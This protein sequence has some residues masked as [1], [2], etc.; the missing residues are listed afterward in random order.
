MTS[1]TTPKEKDTFLLMPMVYDPSGGNKG[2]ARRASSIR[3]L[4]LSIPSKPDQLNNF[5]FPEKPA[6]LFYHRKSTSKRD[7]THAS[8]R[9]SARASFT[10]IDNPSSPDTS[11]QHDALTDELLS[12]LTPVDDMIKEVAK[13]S[14]A[15][16]AESPKE[17]ARVRRI[18]ISRTGAPSAEGVKPET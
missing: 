14:T 2:N 10:S 9:R 1:P 4:R 12:P 3:R 17:R 11:A 7:S 15:M 18:S 16:V 5:T 13:F 6:P 8:R